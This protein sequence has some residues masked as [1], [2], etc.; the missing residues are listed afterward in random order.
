MK[1]SSFIL[2]YFL[3]ML[4]AFTGCQEDDLSAGA[5]IAP[6]N[7]KITVEI[8][9]ANNTNPNGDGSGVVNFKVKADN[10]ISYK[11][12]YNGNEFVA[13]LGSASVIFSD[14]G[15]NTYN[16]SAVAYG[17]GGISSS[18]SIAVNV[19]ATYSPPVDLLEKLIGN[20][21]KTWR[22]KSEKKGH[23]GLGPVGGT[24]PTEWFSANPDEKELTGMYDDRYVFKSDGTFTHITNNT[25]DDPTEDVTGTVFGRKGLI[26]ELGSGSGTVNG[27]DVENYTYSD[28]TENWILITPGG[29]ETISL[30]GLGFIGYYTGGTHTYEIFDRS[31][32]NELLLRTTDGNTE[33][34]W[35][36]IITSEEPSTGNT[37]DV[38]Y[39]NLVWSD[40]FNTNGPPNAANW[41]YD[42]GTGTNGWGN[43]EKQY[44]TNRTDNIIVADGMLKITA[45]SESYSGSNYT[46]ARIKSQGL[47]DF[48]YGRIDVRAKLPEGGGTWPALWMLGANYETAIWPAC[49]EIDIMEHVGNNQNTIHGSI[50]TTSSSGNTVNTGSTTVSNVSSEF[51]IYSV[52]WSGD[53]ISFL[54]DDEIH[55]T[56]NPTIKDATT[57]PFDANQFI[58]F[59][60]A[61]G[62]NMGE[63]IDP[64]FTESTMEIDYVKVYQ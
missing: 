54:I 32:K 55:Y 16:V 12:L 60:I 51:H 13:P 58:I 62:G 20:G 23:F 5:I 64:T 46:S 57:W 52:N 48:K 35:W 29:I 43:N 53:E 14:L 44:Y 36:F 7:I 47:Y 38:T 19:L 49:G 37:V 31:V 50:H 3:V 34:D 17:T 25:N 21:S 4:I 59:N 45:K 15:V 18:T 56:Y 28:Y 24:T 30:T 8:V 9:G 63:T 41:I 11:I 39:T 26:D 33:F 27:D 42:L 22:I 40:E 6:T 2:T 61:M 10:A 1:N